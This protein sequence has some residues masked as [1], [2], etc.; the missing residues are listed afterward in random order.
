MIDPTLL[1]QLLRQVE[2]LTLEDQRRVLD[3]AGSLSKTVDLTSRPQD[4]M[5]LCG[6]LGSKSA[7]QMIQAIEADCERV[8][9]NDW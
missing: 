2:K 5:E 9:L 3:F 1:N 6:T 4:I 7:E 8:D